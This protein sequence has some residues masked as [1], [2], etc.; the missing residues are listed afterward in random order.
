MATERAIRGDEQPTHARDTPT[1]RQVV[2]A[3][4][5]QP[6]TVRRAM[7]VGAADDPLEAEAERTAAAVVRQLRRS[8]EHADAAETN[9]TTGAGRIRRSTIGPPLRPALSEQVSRV[10]SNVI[11]RVTAPADPAAAAT[12]KAHALDQHRRDRAALMKIVRTGAKS[13]DRRTKNACEWILDGRTKLYA[14][15]ATG[16]RAERIAHLG[17][18]PRTTETWFPEGDGGPGDLQ[19]PIASYN[20]LDLDDQTNVNVDTDDGPSTNGWNGDG[21]IAVM[22]RGGQMSSS[23][24]LE[25]LRHEVQHDADKNREKKAAAT[26]VAGDTAANAADRAKSFERYKTEYRAY[27][28]Q[29]KTYDRFSPTKVVTKYGFKWTERQLQIF[30]HIHD[31]YEHTQE[32]W[33]NSFRTA[34]WR[35]AHPGDAGPDA[36]SSKGSFH[37]QNIAQSWKNSIEARR[38]ALVDYVNPDDEEFNKWDSIRVDDFYR[39]LDAVPVGTSDS[40]TK[41]MKKLAWKTGYLGKKDA[42]YILEES[43]DM[44]KKMKAHLVDAAYVHCHKLLCEVAGITTATPLDEMGRSP[45]AR[46]QAVHDA[47]DRVPVGTADN[48]SPLVRELR[49]RTAELTKKDAKQVLEHDPKLLNKIDHHLAGEAHRKLLELIEACRG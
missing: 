7:T 8:V 22:M 20:E 2:P 46:I 14:L 1:G 6:G 42:R 29:G 44:R 40:T 43:P 19:S 23:E 25:T 11:R 10:R 32:F 17:H 37:N 4:R 30:E 41:E 33:D 16:D 35:T 45:S 38:R 24:V 49:R 28:Y 39:A 47:L 27:N 21:Y 13:S 12:R 9:G 18:D 15:N 3:R 31:G 26:P 5:T 34:S 48:A 36:P